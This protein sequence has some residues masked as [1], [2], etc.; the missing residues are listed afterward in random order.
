MKKSAFCCEA[1]PYVAVITT[2]DALHLGP[3][4]AVKLAW[5]CPAA[6]VTLAGTCALAVLLEESATAAPPAG[7]GPVSV[8]VPV[9]EKPQKPLDGEMTSDESDAEAFPLG[10]MVN[11]ALADVLLQEAPA[12]TVTKSWEPT[13]LVEMV[14]EALREPRGTATV[15]VQAGEPVHPE[16]VASLAPEMFPSLIRTETVELASLE[17][18]TRLR[19]TVPVSDAPPVTVDGVS[20]TDWTA[21]AGGVTTT[22]WLSAAPAPLVALTVAARLEVRLLVAVRVP[23]VVLE[24][25][26]ASMLKLPSVTNA[27]A[28]L[29]VTATLVPPTGAGV[30]AGSVP[31]A[32][33]LLPP[34][35]VEMGVPFASVTLNE[36]SAGL[37]SV[38]PG[39]RVS[40][41]VT[42][43]R[44]RP[45]PVESLK[46]ISA[47]SGTVFG[48]ATTLVGSIQLTELVFGKRKSG[49]LQSGGTSAVVPLKLTMAY[50]L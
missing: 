33:A 26:P 44:L 19:F 2:E 11:C 12:A 29:L 46:L 38:P 10:L 48:A 35:M 3:V 28:G 25:H 22:F 1:P 20:V 24:K 14:K 45:A 7:A 27:F 49:G 8:T 21:S 16:K 50:G 34:G 23:A 9:A 40:G 15:P 4:V 5:V 43:T 6:T 31:C 36:A 41:L 37:G 13:A 18:T 47:Q 39:L 42:E 17:S 30:D 32:K